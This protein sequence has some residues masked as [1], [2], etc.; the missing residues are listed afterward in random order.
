MANLPQ[1]SF[2]CTCNSGPGRRQRCPE[3]LSPGMRGHGWPH[4]SAAAGTR[5]SSA[6][7]EPPGHGPG[8]G[9]G[10]ALGTGGLEQGTG[11][12]ES[13]AGD[14]GVKR[15][16]QP[17]PRSTDA[18]NPVPAQT[19]PHLPEHFPNQPCPCVTGSRDQKGERSL[20]VPIERNWRCFSN[21]S[22]FRVWGTWDGLCGVPLREAGTNHVLNQKRRAEMT[23]SRVLAVTFSPHVHGGHCE[24][25]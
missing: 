13:R 23:L 22:C 12:P 16:P 21:T 20:P 11:H 17:K 3:E 18:T 9:A 25:R 15:T 8:Q 24:T 19:T 5:W 2:P 6:T 4:S 14:G 10:L 1:F 7:A